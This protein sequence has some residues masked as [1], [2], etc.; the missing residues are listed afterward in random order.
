MKIKAGAKY[1]RGSPRKARIIADM[2]AGMSPEKAISKLK[3]IRKR[4]VFPIIKVIKQG[5]AN[6]KN[7]LKM[8]DLNDLKITKIEVQEGPR[9]KRMDKSHGARFDRGIIHKKFYH[10]WIV[11]ESLKKNGK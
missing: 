5:M 9:M 3:L 7:N 4:Q 8:T 11:L 2:V 1:L 10:L 6:A